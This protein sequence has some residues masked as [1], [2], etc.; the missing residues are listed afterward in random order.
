MRGIGSV[1]VNVGFYS[2]PKKGMKGINK[3]LTLLFEKQP[4]SMDV[5]RKIKDNLPDKEH[6][7]GVSGWFYVQ[8]FKLVN[9]E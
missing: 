6:N 8:E 9:E 1:I 5:Y 4:S 2:K 7:W 3:K